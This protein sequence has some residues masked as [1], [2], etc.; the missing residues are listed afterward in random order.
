MIIDFPLSYSHL[1][2]K[3]KTLS[4]MTKTFILSV[5]T[6]LL[7]GTH[8]KAQDEIELSWLQGFSESVLVGSNTH[9]QKYYSI[10][11]NQCK[12]K[13]TAEITDKKGNTETASYV[14]Y[15][16]DLNP[17]A[18]SF[19]P[20]GKYV[21]IEMEAKSAQKYIMEYKNEEFQGYI[22][23][24]NLYTDAIDK[25][26]S[27]IDA[28]KSKMDGCKTEGMKWSST[29][30][31]TDWL[32]KNIKT[33]QDGS[34]ENVQQFKQG[35]QLYL[36][37]LTR[38][39]ADSKGVQ[40]IE[41]YILNLADIDQSKVD[42]KVSGKNLTVELNIKDKN[43]YIGFIKD[44]E[45]QSYQ[46]GIEIYAA[47][48]ENARNIILAFE[49]LSKETKAEYKKWTSSGE[50]LS[51]IQNGISAANAG[52]S[53]LEQSFDSKDG[54]IQVNIKTTDSKGVATVL[55]KS[56]YLS[57]LKKNASL[58]V[59]GSSVFVQVEINN[60]DKYVRVF[61]N[62]EVQSYDN[63]IKFEAKNIETAR[64][65]INAI[66]YAISTASEGIPEY[67]SVNDAIAKMVSYTTTVKTDAESTVQK[68]TVDAVMDN[69]L[70]FEKTDADGVSIWDIFPEDI[71]KGNVEIKVVG[72]KLYV[73][74]STGKTKYIAYTKNN[75]Q[76]NYINDFEVYFDDVRNAKI[77]KS[78]VL[79]T[80]ENYKPSS[81][82]LK[83]TDQ[84]IAALKKITS[85]IKIAD[86]VYKQKFET[87]DDQCKIK[88]TNLT[89]DSKGSETEMVYEFIMSDI[90]PVESGIKI[91]GKICGVELSV[92]NNEKLIKPYENGESKNFTN[93]LYIVT[94]DILEAKKIKEA[95]KAGVETC[96]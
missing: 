93:S 44:N 9:V 67:T 78:A 23:K 74:L 22:N 77:F 61:K 17:N 91:S 31:A 57:D 16:S 5:V 21:T 38:E 68:L 50:A 3:L 30:D 65:L 59:S 70:T 79:Y 89:K 48:L 39:Y 54:N 40:H 32:N 81:R 4:I 42:L 33:V 14:F 73:I 43:K 69:K 60:G 13:F 82:I 35:A 45:K 10:E 15:L 53:N 1:C 7:L 56:C 80:K 58:I 90:N 71:D 26:R 75:L 6:I 55:E 76:Q 27:L 64:E 41:E 86:E 28:V 19:K 51:F 52:F 62:D 12:L 95:I 66:D 37:S 94:M 83:G 29:A 96:K 18:I 36:S 72:K 88:F 49:Y 87:E 24:F 46:N 47:D 8:I 84:A 63:E 2:D 92:K 34:V 85:E 11:G 20:T 25:A